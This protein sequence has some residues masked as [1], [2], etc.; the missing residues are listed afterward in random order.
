MKFTISW[1]KEHLETTASLDEIVE[2]MVRVGLEVED[3]KDPAKDLGD[4]TVAEVIE[5]TPHPDADK[6]QVLT[7]NTGKE[8][9][10]VVCAR[11]MLAKASKAS[12]HRLALMSLAST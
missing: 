8:T 1:L 9:L 12:S 10:Q 7:V 5:A 2:T 4:Y 3:I 6:L 11:P